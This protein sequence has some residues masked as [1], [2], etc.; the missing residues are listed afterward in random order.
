M[1]FFCT[2]FFT[3]RNPNILDACDIDDQTKEM[4][5]QDIRH[6]LMPQAVKLRADFEVSCFAYEGIDA[7]RRALHAGLALS[8]DGLPIKINLIAPPLYVLT[9]QTLEWNEGLAQLERVLEAIRNS[10]EEQEGSFKLQQK[11]RVVS[12]TEEADFQRQLEELE[13]ANKEVSGDEDDEDEDDG[14][15]EERNEYEIEDEDEDED[16]EG[17]EGQ[18]IAGAAEGGDS[19]EEDEEQRKSPRSVNNDVKKGKKRVKQR[20]SNNEVAEEE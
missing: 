4:L 20:Q 14:G 2:C 13:D 6:R 19:V 15:D 11:P 12:D 16:E 17:E 9:T 8:T 10:I 18:D 1:I 5:L 7:V 3:F